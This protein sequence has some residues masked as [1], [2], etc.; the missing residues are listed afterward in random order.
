M[1]SRKTPSHVLCNAK[2][3][4]ESTNGMG[5]QKSHET[6]HDL[7]MSEARGSSSSTMLH[8]KSPFMYDEARNPGELAFCCFG[9]CN[10]LPSWTIPASSTMCKPLYNFSSCLFVNNTH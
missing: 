7:E 2:L 10:P 8:I 9:S 3:F 1:A 4:G 5:H 6:R